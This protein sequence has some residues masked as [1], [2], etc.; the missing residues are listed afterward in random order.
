MQEQK[1]LNRRDFLRLS[2]IAS[3]GVLAAACGAA[4]PA[5][6]PSAGGEAAPVAAPVSA[7]QA[8]AAA[9]G[10]KDVPREKT[11]ILMWAGT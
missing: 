3:A 1:N 6:A 9:A 10:L 8:S 5:A 4:A 11:L 2:G 7:E